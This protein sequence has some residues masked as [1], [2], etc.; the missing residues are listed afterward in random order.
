MYKLI[1]FSILFLFS[2]L[3]SFAAQSQDKKELEL[4]EQFWGKKGEAYKGDEVPEKWKKESAVILYQEF[5]FEYDKSSGKIYNTAEYHRRVKLQDK[6]AVKDYSEFSFSETFRGQVGYR[7]T[8]GKTFVG[9]KIIKPDGTEKIVDLKDAANIKSDEDDDSSVRKLAIPGLQEGDII[10]YYYFIIERFKADNSHIFTP[11]LTTLNSTYPI[12]YQRLEF[13]VEKNF[14]ISFRPTNGAPTL[15]RK[16]DKKRQTYTSVEKDIERYENRL[17][18]YRYR[19]LPTIKF[20]VVYNRR[21]VP[22]PAFTA[23]QGVA[24]K[25]VSYDDVK[26]MLMPSL[27]G[28][29]YT[30]DAF[31]KAFKKFSKKQG[32]QK[33]SEEQWVERGY[34]YLYHYMMGSELEKYYLVDGAREPGLSQYGFVSAM[35]LFL[36]K[37]SIPHDLIVT[38]PRDI[39]EIKDLMLFQEMSVLLRIRLDDKELYLSNFG[40]HPRFNEIPSDYEGASAY[41]IP[42]GKMKGEKEIVLPVSSKDD[43]HSK[44]NITASFIT[45]D[46]NKI[47]ITSDHTLKRHNRIW[48]QNNFINPYDFLKE[49]YEYYGELPYVERGKKRKKREQQALEQRHKEFKERLTENRKERIKSNVEDDYKAEVKEVKKFKIEELGRSIEKPDMEFSLEV[50]VEGLIKKAGPNLILE[51]GRLITTQIEVPEEQMQRSHDIYMPFARSYDYKITVDIPEG[52]TVEGTEKLDFNV[53]N[54]TGGFISKATVEGSQL[55]IDT[56]KYYNHNY[57]PAKKWSLMLTFLEAAYDFTK[58]KVLLKKG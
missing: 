16:S 6:A 28:Y 17:W 45:D 24:N 40:L 48:S 3:F 15:T 12:R 58:V 51:V 26:K 55:V 34:Y 4:R 32:W 46:L 2:L 10:D 19:S 53:E 22:L 11:V 33:I 36:D 8:K 47:R 50:E 20:Q 29:D 13:S 57:E 23:G 1:R 39:A 18:M 56:R 41:V 30:G 54:S 5:R 44:V 35:H 25:S 9:F 42:F 31:Y 37:R 43:N 21:G 38:I 52:Y 14:Y 49:E 27:Q 7:S